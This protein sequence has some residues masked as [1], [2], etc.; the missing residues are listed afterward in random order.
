M[1]GAFIIIVGLYMVLWGKNTDNLNKLH[2]SNDDVEKEYKVSEIVMNDN[3]V[4]DSNR[5]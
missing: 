4:M 1:I 5:T 3:S 2:E